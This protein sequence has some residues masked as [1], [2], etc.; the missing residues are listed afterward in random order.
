M[1][2]ENSRLSNI[3]SDDL[4]CD[5]KDTLQTIADTGGTKCRLC[6]FQ[7]TGSDYGEILEELGRHAEEAH[8]NH[9]LLA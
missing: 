6:G 7:V 5:L 1:T 2:K 9:F 3:R 8:G 4:L